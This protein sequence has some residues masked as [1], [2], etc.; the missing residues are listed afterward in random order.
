MRAFNMR[1]GQKFA[2]A[3]FVAALAPIV[4]FGYYEFRATGRQLAD[5]KLRELYANCVTRAR[6]LEMS[7][8]NLYADLRYLRSSQALF[9]LMDS[10]AKKPAASA[11][12]RGLAEKEFYRFLTLKPEYSR[13]GLIDNHGNEVAVLFRNG[14]DIVS[15]DKTDLLNRLTDPF[16]V[17]AGFGEGA[18]ITA[19]PMRNAAD[20]GRALSEVT[21]MRYATTLYDRNN[22]A[23]YL[24]YV[25]MNG[26]HAE[27]GLTHKTFDLRRA[28]SLVTSKGRFLYDASKNESNPGYSPAGG[29][30]D[31][32]SRLPHLLTSQIL[33]G[34]PGVIEDD[35]KALYAYVPVYPQ[36]GTEKLYYVIFDSYRKDAL[37]EALTPLR[38]RYL[39]GAVIAFTLATLLALIVSGALTRNIRRLQDGVANFTS[40][41]MDY[42]IDI[43]SGDE[44]EQL[45]QAYNAMAAS[46]R[47]YHESMEKQVRERTEQ[48]RKVEGRLTHA[49]K[50]AAIGFL[51]AGM[52][53]EVNN[54]ISIIVTRLELMRR[55][56]GRGNLVSL[57]KDLDVVERHA[58]R[59]GEIA[60]GLLT[61]ARDVKEEI[62]FIDLNKV[63]SRMAGLIEHSVDKKG[64]SIEVDLDDRLPEV[65]ASEKGVEQSMYNLLYN[66]WQALSA[67]CR[68]MVSTVRVDDQRVAII[69]AD[70][71]PGIPADII[72]KIFDP[73]FTTKDP[74]EGTGLGLSISYGLI[75]ECGGSLSVSSEPG[76]GATFTIT[77]STSAVDTAKTNLDLE[78]SHA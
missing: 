10:P 28:A 37:N 61:F 9:F 21:L 38:H 43:R 67:G 7:F 35:S 69:V 74:G 76:K 73:F 18:G 6:V 5:A 71:G 68:I 63:V 20:P 4:Y 70:T 36:K 75:Q 30:P 23:R 56:L 45:A 51:A 42:H 22:K 19:I 55:E 46:L 25:D 49:E 32:Q 26:A 52:A 2:V 31:I 13:V 59:I 78:Q 34:R 33:S 3:L 64:I 57:E 60:G 27:F 39:L 15:L 66:A 41:R 48:V 29:P 65:W 62:G 1:I 40:R 50:L 47:E 11:Y 17:Q 58:A 54:P 53:H 24:L 16:F 44:I 8:H 72:D 77:L 12:W 14:A